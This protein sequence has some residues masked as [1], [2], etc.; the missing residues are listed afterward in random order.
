MALKG[1]GRLPLPQNLINK[2][3]EELVNV[4]ARLNLEPDIDKLEAAG[5]KAFERVYKLLDEGIQPDDATLQTIESQVAVQ[6]NSQLRQQVKGGIRD[7]RLAA[8]ESL[9]VPLTWVAQGTGS[10]PS[11]E[12]R[13][14]QTKSYSQ[15]ASQGLPGSSALICQE[16]CNCSLL[17]NQK[18]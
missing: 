18:P 12:K 3:P 4:L 10:C 11:C 9:D 1:P 15:W 13:H 7:Y 16:E 8:F 5:D 6:V 14:G 17:P 2:T